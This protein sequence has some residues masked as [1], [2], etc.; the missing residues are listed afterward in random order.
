MVSN[1]FWYQIA[2]YTPQQLRLDDSK[3]MEFKHLVLK[4]E[5]CACRKL[6]PI[7]AQLYF[8]LL[9]NL[10]QLWLRRLENSG[11]INASKHWW[12]TG[13]LADFHISFSQLFA[14]SESCRCEFWWYFLSDSRSFRFRISDSERRLLLRLYTGKLVALAEKLPMISETVAWKRPMKAY[15]DFVYMICCTLRFTVISK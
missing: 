4:S 9:V 7:K 6:A 12:I 5:K 2:K 3:C 8:P 13:P 15:E 10:R 1:Y 14:Y 11:K